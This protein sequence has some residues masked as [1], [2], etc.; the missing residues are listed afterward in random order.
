M[1]FEFVVIRLVSSGPIRSIG[2]GD[3]CRKLR[4]KGWVTRLVGTFTQNGRNLPPYTNRGAENTYSLS[5][6]LEALVDWV[7]FTLPVKVSTTYIVE[8]LLQMKDSDF[9]V[10]DTGMMGYKGRLMADGIQILYDGKADMGVHVVLSGSGCRMVE[11]KVLKGNAEQWKDFIGFVFMLEG[12]FS[13]FDVAIDDKAG[14]FTVEQVLDEC[15]AGN[16]RSRF[17]TGRMMRDFELS[18]GDT[19]GSTVYFGDATSRLRVRI[20]DKAQEQKVEGHWVRTELQARNER[21]TMIASLIADGQAVGTIA[22]GALSNYIN[23]VDGSETEDTNKARWPLA[24]WW[25][26]FLQDVEKVRLTVKKLDKTIRDKF[27]WLRNQVAPT[28]SLLRL[29][30]GLDKLQDFVESESTH[31]YSRLKDRHLRLLPSVHGTEAWT[32]TINK[33]TGEQPA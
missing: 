16:V 31:S 2:W 6:G 18:T 30:M 17:R 22:L 12:K 33:L 7:S 3:P 25:Q 5:Q 13:R 27:V 10:M 14:Y 24:L 29:Y 15:E 26:C 11:E 19:N 4:M 8:S 1:P 32:V 28:L 21:A 20:Y 9:Q 23:F